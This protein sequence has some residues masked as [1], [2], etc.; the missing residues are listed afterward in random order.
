M[1]TIRKEISTKN[2]Y[3]FSLGFY[4]FF[5]V[6]FFVYKKIINFPSDEFYNLNYVSV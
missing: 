5:S 4:Y 2:Y 6:G 3:Y 1:N